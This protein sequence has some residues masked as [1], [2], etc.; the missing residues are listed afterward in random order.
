M[1]LLQLLLSFARRTI[2]TVAENIHLAAT[3]D[4]FIVEV[5]NRNHVLVKMIDRT[6]DLT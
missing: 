4:I 3:T 5:R 6:V 2:T 1:L